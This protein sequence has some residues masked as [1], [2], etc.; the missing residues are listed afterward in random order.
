MQGLGPVISEKA[1]LKLCLSN[2][3]NFIGPPNQEK[4]N[5]EIEGLKLNYYLTLFSSD[6][7]ITICIPQQIPTY[8]WFVY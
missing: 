3:F 4:I 1:H 5:E 7:L 6:I 2:D 8:I